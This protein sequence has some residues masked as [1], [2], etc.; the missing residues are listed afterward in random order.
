MKAI[1]A[2]AFRESRSYPGRIRL[3]FALCFGG[4]AWL[5][6]LA[7]LVS[8]TQ[9]ILHPTGTGGPAPNSIVLP[10]GICLATLFA[11]PGA[12]ICALRPAW[13]GSFYPRA[14]R[15]AAIMCYSLVVPG[16][17]LIGAFSLYASFH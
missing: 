17:L 10:I 5:I 6:V 8:L 4:I 9:I 14:W 2:T 12:I 7:V 1:E 16:L 3:A 15:A 11:A 13:L